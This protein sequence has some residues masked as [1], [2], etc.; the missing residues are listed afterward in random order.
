MIK[1]IL[2]GLGGTPFTTVAVKIATELGNLHQ[3]QLTGVT[4]LD[5]RKLDNV[6]PVPVGGGAY[7]QRMRERKARITKEGTEQAITAFKTHC[8]EQQ[9]VCRR[10]EYEQKDPFTAMVSEARYNDITIFGL[11]SIFDYGFTSDPDKAIIKLMTQ[12]VRPILAVADTYRPIKKALIAYSGSMESAKAIRHFLH[13][14][15]WPGVTL[16]IV[17]FK[18]G[19]EREPFLLKDAAEFCEAHG[20]EVETE[21]VEGQARLN[22]LPFAQESNADLIVMGN[23][24]NRAL[25]QRLLGDT[26]LETIKSA[27]RPLFLSQ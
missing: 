23:S 14:N 15:P 18:E 21:I 20:F 27:D 19:R 17:H 7:A 8:S 9:V 10:I 24:V 26:V 2:V 6:G 16:H 13:L 1:R 22:L 12:G 4:V 5:T 25:L 11:R 3:A